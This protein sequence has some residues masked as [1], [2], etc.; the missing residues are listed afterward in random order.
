MKFDKID[1]KFGVKRQLVTNEPVTY[2]GMQIKWTLSGIF[3]SQHEFVTRLLQRFKS[4]DVN[5]A[6]TPIEIGMMTDRKKIVRNKPL[7][8]LV[9]YR[10]AV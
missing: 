8:K 10:K 6:S 5:P 2:L 3:A 7:S 4:V 9:S 1:N